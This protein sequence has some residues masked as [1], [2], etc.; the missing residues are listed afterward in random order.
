MAYRSKSQPAGPAV[1]HSTQAGPRRDSVLEVLE[2]ELSRSMGGF[3]IPGNPRPYYV[4]YALRRVHALRLRAMYGSLSRA[5]ETTHSS[6]YCDLRVGSHKF[7]NVLDAGLD[8][9]AED[10]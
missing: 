6:V 7:D 3:K 2:R 10:R 9:H 5:R 1:A 4:H 8:Y